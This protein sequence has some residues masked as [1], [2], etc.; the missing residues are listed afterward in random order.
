MFKEAESGNLSDFPSTAWLSSGGASR[1][2]LCLLILSSP[3]TFLQQLFYV[4]N[5]GN[6]VD[7]VDT[8]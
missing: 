7:N 1:L 8:S 6:Y 3:L 5:K 4:D 2:G